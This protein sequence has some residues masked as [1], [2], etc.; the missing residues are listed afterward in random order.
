MLLP[1]AAG[2]AAV[3]P[4]QPYL[5]RVA[6]Q[7]EVAA[8]AQ[9]VALGTAED[10]GAAPAAFLADAAA[11]R[12][13]RPKLP[14]PGQ[15]NILITSALP[16]VNNVPH[17]GNIIGCVLRWG[18]GGG[19]GCVAGCGLRC[20][21]AAGGPLRGASVRVLAGCVPAS[22]HPGMLLLCPAPLSP[23]HPPSALP[24][25]TSSPLPSPLLHYMVPAAPTCMPASA[26][27]AATT[28]CTCAVPTSS[29]LPPR[30]R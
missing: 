2:S 27:P 17:L 9:Q 23:G 24:L 1:P 28:W 21:W 14:I 18:L 10:G 6:A 20:G 8:A 30:P 19:W 22:K 5:S 4:L 29:V 16:Y 13:A 11:C 15:R 25:P 12:A 3:A 7:P 26:V